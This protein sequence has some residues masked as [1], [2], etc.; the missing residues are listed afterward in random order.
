[1]HRMVVSVAASLAACV[2]DS[3][4]VCARCGVVGVVSWHSDVCGSVPV[5]EGS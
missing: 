5:L 4:D 1:M 2:H 3:G